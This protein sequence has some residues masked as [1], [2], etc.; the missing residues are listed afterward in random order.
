MR[1]PHA[2]ALLLLAAACSDTTDLQKPPD[3]TDPVFAVADRSLWAGSAMAIESEAFTDLASAP[4]VQL[5]GISLEVSRTGPETFQAILPVTASGSY[6]PTISLGKGAHAL[7]SITV[8]GFSGAEEFGFRMN[9]G[10]EAMPG[11]GHATLVGASIF[12]GESEGQLSYVHLDTGAQELFE[13][14]WYEFAQLRTPGASYRPGVMFG[15]TAE[16]IRP[17]TVTAGNVV[18]EDPIPLAFAR[19]IAELAEGVYLVTSHHHVTVSDGSFMQQVEESQS[20]ALSHAA[21]R[22]TVSAGNTQNIGLPVFTV[23]GGSLAYLLTEVFRPTA[24]EFSPDG[25]LL[26]VAGTEPAGNMLRIFRASDGELIDEQTLPGQPIAIAFDPVRPLLYVGT[27]GVYGESGTSKP[28]LL[29]F[30]RA[31]FALLGHMSSAAAELSCEFG[32]VEA[33]IAVSAEPAV[34]LAGFLNSPLRAF[35]FSIP[36]E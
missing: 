2:A 32:C 13:G 30:D 17:L 8:A 23:P 7:P 35:R 24:V 28:S 22:A 14:P 25:L 11:T 10:A 19:Q 36:M 21:G 3:P 16:G 9:L 29:V 6:V 18:M 26:A 12:P 1:I 33:E 15:Q 20:I 4:D 27:G 31:T 5:D 34:Y